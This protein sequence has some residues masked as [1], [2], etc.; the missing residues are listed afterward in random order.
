M[1][2]FDSN[3]IIAS[4]FHVSLIENA[5]SLLPIDH[6]RAFPLCFDIESRKI[7]KGDLNFYNKPF[8]I[9]LILLNVTSLK[10]QRVPRTLQ[11]IMFWIIVLAMHF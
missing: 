5:V 10:G 6:A 1:I 8:L 11:F 2:N 3:I 9:I 7:I 4:Y